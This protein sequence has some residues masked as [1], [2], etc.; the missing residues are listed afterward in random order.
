[1]KIK[2]RSYLQKYRRDGAVR[3]P[4]TPSGRLL[5]MLSSAHYRPN[6]FKPRFINLFNKISRGFKP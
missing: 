1:M 3:G 5:E 4:K 6:R 2:G